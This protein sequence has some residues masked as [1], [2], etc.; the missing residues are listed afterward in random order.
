LGVGAKT[1]GVSGAESTRYW[2][3]GRGEEFAAYCRNDVEL[4][5]TIHSRMIGR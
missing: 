5:R 1:E 3:E 2:R 4:L